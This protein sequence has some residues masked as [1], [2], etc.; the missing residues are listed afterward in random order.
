MVGGIVIEA[1]ER[2]GKIFVDC[3]DRQYSDTCAIWVE[4]NDDSVLIRIGDTVWWQ[5]D[6]AM[7]TPC[8]LEFIGVRQ[9][10]DFDIRIPRIGYS[11]VELDRSKACLA[12]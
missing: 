7:W 4:K 3:R 11:G 1:A 9:G 8:G 12:S 10:V 6:W 5:G 2:D